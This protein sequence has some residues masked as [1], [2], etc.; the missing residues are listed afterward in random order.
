M[1]GVTLTEGELKTIDEYFAVA[2]QNTPLDYFTRSL[3][4]NLKLIGP[5]YWQ[6]HADQLCSALN[7]ESD[8]LGCLPCNNE[9]T[10]KAFG[11]VRPSDKSKCNGPAAPIG[12]TQEVHCNGR[13]KV[14]SQD[15]PDFGDA[16]FDNDSDNDTIMA[17]KSTS[18]D[19]YHKYISMY[20]ACAGKKSSDL[21][22][23]QR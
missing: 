4:G 18:T 2:Q 5:N 10:M 13:Y 6:A 7:I 16:N 17:S 19:P 11:C 15:Q 12:A 23:D 8:C 22:E 3:K 9:G 1:N 20:E 14:P 21:Y